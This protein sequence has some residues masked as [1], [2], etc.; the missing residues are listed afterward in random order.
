[1]NNDKTSILF[2]SKLNLDLYFIKIN[3]EVH[4]H[5]STLNRKIELL[6]LNFLKKENLNSKGRRRFR[7]NYNRFKSSTTGTL[8]LNND[9]PLKEVQ[10]AYARI[11]YLQ[12]ELSLLKARLENMEIRYKPK[13]SNYTFDCDIANQSHIIDNLVQ[14]NV[15]SDTNIVSQSSLNKGLGL[16]NQSEILLEDCLTIYNSSLVNLKPKGE[17]INSDLT[18]IGSPKGNKLNK[19]RYLN[20]SDILFIFFFILFWGNFS[21]EVKPKLIKKK[22]FPI[23]GKFSSISKRIWSKFFMLGK[24]ICNYSDT[25]MVE[26]YKSTNGRFVDM[27]QSAA[28][29]VTDDSVPPDWFRPEILRSITG[30]YGFLLWIPNPGWYNTPTGIKFNILIHYWNKVFNS[31]GG[32]TDYDYYNRITAIAKQKGK[33]YFFAL[34]PR[35]CTII[36]LLWDIKFGTDYITSTKLA[37]EH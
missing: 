6:E 11:I 26:S 21:T 30:S 35:Y 32:I 7:R 19:L 31:F 34:S 16:N 17:K 13:L 23:E 14:P 5:L 37:W 18:N 12:D 1:M 27:L 8:T 3:E 33:K 10:L 36:L 25:T 9:V 28:N 22:K 29:Q 20:I 24:I 2:E 15:D 4:T